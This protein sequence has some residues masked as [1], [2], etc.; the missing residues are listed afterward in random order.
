M[1][2]RKGRCGQRICL[3]YEDEES[4]HDEAVS[5]RERSAK[6]WQSRRC[7]VD[8]EDREV[9]GGILLARENA[10]ARGAYS[11]RGDRIR[12]GRAQ[13]IEVGASSLG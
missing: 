4:P 1:L 8:K 11:V 10:V 9:G 3:R 5:S 6:A 7:I 13:W 12:L 2:H